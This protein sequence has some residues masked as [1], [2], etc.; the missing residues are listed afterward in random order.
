MAPAKKRQLL[1]SAFENYLIRGTIAGLQQVIADYTGVANIR[2]LE[3]FRFRNWTSLPLPNGLDRGVRL[4]SNNFYARLQVGVSSRVGSF[5]LTN[6]PQPAVEPNDFGANKFSLLFP[7]N[8][9]TANDAKAAI[10]KVLDREKPAHTE[11]I[12]CPIFPRL[13]IGVQA[14]LGVDAYVGKTNSTILGKLAT[15]SFDSILSRSQ[16][17]RDIQ[18]IGFSLH[19]R[20]GMDARIL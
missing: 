6:A 11:A 18:A 16:A 10:Q 14:T 7:A 2:I 9:Y 19:A 20:L 13:R 4:W 8:P 12:L 15:L 17:E 1:K 3:H 5:R